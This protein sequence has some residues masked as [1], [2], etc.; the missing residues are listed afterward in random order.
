MI[1]MSKKFLDS[2]GYV[3]FRNIFSVEDIN[4]LRRECLKILPEQFPPFKPQ[5][6]AHVLDKNTFVREEIFGNQKLIDAMRSV[7]G[8]DFLLIDE[9]GLQDSSYATP[10]ADTTSPERRGYKFHLKDD[11]LVTQWAL[12]LQDNGS[13]G[14]GLSV[15]PKSHM[16]PDIYADPQRFAS[17][18]FRLNRFLLKT[19][20]SGIY[21]AF[22]L[23]L[24]T[25]GCIQILKLFR[26]VVTLSLRLWKKDV[27][28]Q[29]KECNSAGIRNSYIPI[30]SK[31]GDVVCFNL[32]CWH[33]ATP[34][35]EFPQN[36]SNRKLAIFFV[37][38][39]NNPL[40]K[41]YKAWINLY[42]DERYL[43]KRKLQEDFL[44]FLNEKNINFL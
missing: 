24:L 11:F 25:R 12:Y 8:D 39:K 26:S 15:V 9:H 16:R 21:R 20:N 41:K 44:M 36:T 14:G 6:I 10:H 3:V 33:E 30:E 35:S 40:T 2:E 17:I 38:G 22:G 37:A 23:Y 34:A 28:F 42:H 5:S 27:E 31:A 1:D 4:S 13:N 29:I 32:R 7:L 18:E 43:G 19:S